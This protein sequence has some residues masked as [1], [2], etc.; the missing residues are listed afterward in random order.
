MVRSTG[1]AR[2]K[3]EAAFEKGTTMN[4]PSMMLA[5]IVLNNQ[6][7]QW[8]EYNQNPLSTREMYAVRKPRSIKQVLQKALTA[9]TTLASRLTRRESEHVEQ[10]R[11]EKTRQAS[12]S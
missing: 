5:V 2:G 8:E 11:I 4:D 6:K 12:L 10:P 3:A 7:R 1:Y 9:G